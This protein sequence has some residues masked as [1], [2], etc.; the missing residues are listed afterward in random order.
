VK[1]NDVEDDLMRIKKSKLCF[2]L[3]DL[4]SKLYDNDQTDELSYFILFM[5]ANGLNNFIKILLDVNN[6]NNLISNRSMLADCS[7][8]YSCIVL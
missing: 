4:L 2:K 3:N 1:L 6:F 7:G 5:D 8:I